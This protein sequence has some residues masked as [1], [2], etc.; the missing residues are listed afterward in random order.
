[1]YIPSSFAVNDPTKLAEVI[2]SNSFGI[3]I[4]KDGDSF[5]ASHLPF[6]YHPQEG[7]KG[8]LLSHMARAN[9]HWQLFKEKEEVFVIFNGPHAYISPTNYITEVAVPTWNY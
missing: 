5:F 1:M 9:R 8:K 4:S 3:L 7:K 2:S 6:L